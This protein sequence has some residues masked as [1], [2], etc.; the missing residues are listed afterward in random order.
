MI[1]L[2]CG[3]NYPA[4]AELCS[5]CHFM[6]KGEKRG[7]KT[8]GS[9]FMQF[10]RASEELINQEISTDDYYRVI[11]N[12]LSVLDA[13]EVNIKED[14]RS[15]GLYEAPPEAGRAVEQPVTNAE[16]GVKL[17]RQLLNKLKKNL[18]TID[19]ELINKSLVQAERAHGYLLLAEQMAEYGAAELEKAAAK[20]GKK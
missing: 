2:K 7:D 15:T 6:L 11:E 4:D 14:A 12:M 1:C 19:E 17:Y 13:I 3:R 9:H 20:A 5:E 18:G 10:V 8:F 16:K